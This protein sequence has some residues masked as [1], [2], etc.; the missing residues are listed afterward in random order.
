MCTSKRRELFVRLKNGE[1]VRERIIHSELA[2]MRSKNIH[3]QIKK[4]IIKQAR[5]K[6]EPNQFSIKLGK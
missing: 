2:E 1:D 6:F 4:A 5:P 3:S